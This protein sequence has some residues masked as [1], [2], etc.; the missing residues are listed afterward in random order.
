MNYGIREAFFA[1]Y[2]RLIKGEFTLM[3]II[4]AFE[5]GVPFIPLF[6]KKSIVS[7][8]PNVSGADKN[9]IYSSINDWKTEN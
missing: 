4:E 9:N 7:I 2:N 3:N 5:T 1:E 8:N 6:Y